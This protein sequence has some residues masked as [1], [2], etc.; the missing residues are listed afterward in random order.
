MVTDP[1]HT[2]RPGTM[3]IGHF[4]LAMDPGM[5][6]DAADFRADVAAFCDTLRATK[7]VDPAKPVRSRA[8]PNAAS[9]RGGMKPASPSAPAC[10]PR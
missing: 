4:M 3:D 8:I 5:F 6:R 2:K 1:M 7:P 9:R 10:W